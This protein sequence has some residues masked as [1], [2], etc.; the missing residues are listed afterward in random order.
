MESLNRKLEELAESDLYP[1]HMP[2]HKRNLA[3]GIENVGFSHDITEITEFDNLHQ[4]EGIIDQIQQKVASFY[5]AKKS[6]LLV[7]GSSCGNLAAISAS[8]K[9][10][11]TILVQR[12]CHRSV[13][14][15]I[16]IRDLKAEYIYPG[17]DED[18]HYLTEVTLKDIEIAFQ[19][20]PEIEAV[21]ITSPTYE[22][23][24]SDIRGIADI[25]H[26]HNAILIVDE[27]HGA[28]FVLDE[29]VS[30]MKKETS[31]IIFETALSQGADI[32]INSLHKTMPSL[33]QTAVLHCNSNRVDQERLKKFLRIY[34]TSSPSY[35]L[36][37]SIEQ[38]ISYAEVN[39]LK[40]WVGY[41][42]KLEEFYASTK[43]LYRLHVVND[44]ESLSNTKKGRDFGKIIISTKNSAISGQTL[45]DILRER[46]RLQLEMAQVDYVLALTSVMDKEEGFRRLAAALLE[47]DTLLPKW[48]EEGSITVKRQCSNNVLNLNLYFKPKQT[49]LTM[50][51]ADGLKRKT[52]L[53]E[54][55]AGCICADEISIYPPG[56]PLLL[57]GERLDTQMVDFLIEAV[58]MGITVH[59]LGGYRQSEIT[60]ISEEI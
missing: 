22:G 43:D 42:A 23:V 60:I 50:G 5:G 37:S 59:G 36:M 17:W 30:R 8:V 6:Y 39:A 52:I 31:N 24:V 11:G 26:Q 10:N 14:Y 25:A 33:T 57:P 38:C 46:Y 47:I 2:G 53:L 28:H 49:V 12:N 19:K 56:I 51:E 45:Y 55:S 32:V 20:N 48:V 15:G 54:D 29:N 40:L 44:F 35:L 3:M 34:Q 4:P 27:A 18:Y 1:F 9:K 16:F 41:K 13:F 58:C 7:N 21:V